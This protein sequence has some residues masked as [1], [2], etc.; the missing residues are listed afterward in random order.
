MT[1][2][3]K[4]ILILLIVLCSSACSFSQTIVVENL[5]ENYLTL[6]IDNEII[7]SVENVPCSEIEVETDNGLI[8]TSKKCGHFILVPLSKWPVTIKIFRKTNGQL[9]FLEERKFRTKEFQTRLFI[10]IENCSKKITLMELKQAYKAMLFAEGFDWDAESVFKIEK[11]K[12]DLIYKT[13]DEIKKI[14]N[15]SN[16]F[17]KELI[18]ALRLLKPNDEIVIHDVYILTNNN[19][20][21][22]LDSLDYLI[23]E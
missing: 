7:I 1:L 16:H 9:T 15:F 6:G 2:Y 23:T 5:R 14:E 17:S 19:Y 3:I 22:K 11:F 13:K 10:C 8:K 18:D 4:Y 21:M 20:Q 12:V